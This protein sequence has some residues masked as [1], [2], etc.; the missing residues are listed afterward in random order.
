MRWVRVK[1][2]TNDEA[3][4][5]VSAAMEALGTGGTLFENGPAAIGYL[6]GD[7]RFETSL[8]TL[9]DHLDRMKE[10]GLD[11]APATITLTFEDDQDWA[12][13][14]KEHYHPISVTESLTIVPSWAEYTAAEGEN[15]IRL[16]PGMAFGTGGHATTRLCIRALEEIVEAAVI[17]ADI[18]TGS[19]ILAIAAAML[20]AERIDAVDTDPVAVQVARENVDMNGV[21]DRVNVKVGDRMIGMPGNYDLVIANILPN[22]VSILASSA[23]AKLKQNGVYLVSGLTIPYEDDV[24]EALLDAGFEIVQRWEEERWVALAA[25]KV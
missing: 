10:N 5:A 11:P 12:N 21:S 9:R 4:D 8:E 6:P 13:A 1:V 20:G 23:A 16:D 2:V 25:R 7:D 18:G 24:R 19:G 17:A 14:W 15:I 22:V 3:L